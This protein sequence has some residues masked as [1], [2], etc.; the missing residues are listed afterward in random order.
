MVKTKWRNNL[1]KMSNLKK[2]EEDSLPGFSPQ[3]EKRLERSFGELSNIAGNIFS[4]QK[5]AKSIY[6]SSCFRGEGKS[7]AAKRFAFGL[8][9][10]SQNKVLLIDT[11][12]GAF[13]TLS[14]TLELEE[15]LGFMDVIFSGTQPEEVIRETK[16]SRL[17][18]IP[19][20]TITNQKITLNQ[21]GMIGKTLGKLLNSYDYVIIDGNSILGS[22][23]VSLIADSFDAIAIVVKCEKTKWEVLQMAA[24]KIE[25]SGGNLLGVILNARKYYIPRF[26]YGKM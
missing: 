4:L 11:C 24:N 15:E 23:D 25:T 14:K 6:I 20:G 21:K 9:Q 7:T 17:H 12:K 8:S 19:F 22:S 2:A 18:F 5:Q 26:L 1:I 16:Y 13:P 10:Q 3:E